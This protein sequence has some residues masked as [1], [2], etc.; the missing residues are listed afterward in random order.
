MHISIM[1]RM[2]RLTLALQV[3]H[4]K[5]DVCHLVFTN[6]ESALIQ[7]R[8]GV[9]PESILQC[10]AACGAQWLCTMLKDAVL[11]TASNSAELAEALEDL[12]DE[13][14]TTR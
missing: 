3:L 14:S 6:Q 1:Q 12:A 8:N 10:L 11:D 9:R 7:D 2:Q 5:L 4:G 13:L